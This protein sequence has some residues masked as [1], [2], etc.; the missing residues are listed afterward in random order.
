MQLCYGVLCPPLQYYPEKD[1][2]N[3]AQSGAMLPDLVT[4]EFAYLVEQLKKA[5]Q[6]SKLQPNN[7]SVQHPEVDF[8]NDWKLMTILAGFNDLCLGWETRQRC[9]HSVLIMFFTVAVQET[10]P[11]SRLMISKKI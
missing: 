3:A 11:L 5:S 8:E 1:V 4:H 9:M 7:I 10:I 2:F 6:S